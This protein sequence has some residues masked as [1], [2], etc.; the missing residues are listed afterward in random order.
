MFCVFLFNFMTETKADLEELMTDIKKLANK[1]RSKLKSESFIFNNT[2]CHQLHVEALKNRLP[3]SSPVR[4]RLAYFS[5]NV[6]DCSEI[7]AQLKFY[8]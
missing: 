8:K 1:V 2:R 6:I 5:L 4:W 7:E 3:L